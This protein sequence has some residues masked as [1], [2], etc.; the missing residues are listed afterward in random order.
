MVCSGFY[1]LF[2]NNFRGFLR[3]IF[4]WLVF[5]FLMFSY[6]GKL[7]KK[8]VNWFLCGGLKVLWLCF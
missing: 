4:K 2:M 3:F 7:K 8:R 6:Y 5:F 1:E